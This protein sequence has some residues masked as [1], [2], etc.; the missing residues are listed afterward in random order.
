ML[1]GY[2]YGLFAVD[3]HVLVFG[4][5]VGRTGG[6]AE[7]VIFVMRHPCVFW[8]TLG[9]QFK[10]KSKTVDDG[11]NFGGIAIGKDKSCGE[12]MVGVLM[13]A[14]TGGKLLAI[15][16]TFEGPAGVWALVRLEIEC[17]VPCRRRR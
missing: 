2:V 12:T 5:V 14:R 10:N 8:C 3:V 16:M 11:I 4:C 6:D 15:T 13:A 17:M 9:A 7:H 1:C